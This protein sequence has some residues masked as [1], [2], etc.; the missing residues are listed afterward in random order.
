MNIAVCAFKGGVGKTTTA[1][2]LA[3]ALS[4]SEGAEVLA[5]DLDRTQHDLAHFADNLSGVE[6][7]D[8]TAGRLRRAVDAHG[9]TRHI[10]IDCAPALGRESLAAL[11]VADVAV[12]PIIADLLSARDLPRF[13]EV[14]AAAQAQRAQAGAQPLRAFVLPQLFDGT[15]AACEILSAIEGVFAEDEDVTVWEPIARS[16]AVV[17]ANNQSEPVVLAAPRCAPARTYK[18][19]ARA[20]IN[21][22]VN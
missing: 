11:L 16:K 7:R 14:L 5:L 13:T 3:V 20:I 1:A 22:E 21:T 15:D 4:Q 9:K 17:D 12:F 6:V 10:V 19:L 18:A 8:S 2:N